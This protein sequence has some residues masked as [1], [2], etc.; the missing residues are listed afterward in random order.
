[1]QKDFDIVCGRVITLKRRITILLI[2]ALACAVL[3]GCAGQ[4]APETA[5]EQT[6]DKTPVSMSPSAPAGTRS[7]RQ[8]QSPAQV[9]AYD[10]S[11]IPE[12]KKQEGEGFLAYGDLYIKIIGIEKAMF[13]DTPG[14]ILH[15]ELTN[16]GGS[17]IDTQGLYVE[18]T[19]NAKE[20]RHPPAFEPVYLTIDTLA[21]GEI[22]SYYDEFILDTQTD[23]LE[24][25]IRE[26]LVLVP[27]PFWVY[28]T[29]S[30]D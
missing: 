4:A 20:L 8:T 7:P 15:Y 5:P 25:K 13:E 14:V 12:D 17:G 26:F 16:N 1:M 2:L 19:Q 6:P 21:P 24:V 29:F 22:L 9:P 18:V 3:A 30:L 27:D 23:P 10:L 28:Q 11:A